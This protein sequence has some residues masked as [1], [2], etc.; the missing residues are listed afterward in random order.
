MAKTPWEIIKTNA[1][2]AKR[3]N[4][5]AEAEKNALAREE[6]R[7]LSNIEEVTGKKLTTVEEITKE[8]EELTRAVSERMSEMAKVLLEVDYLSEDDKNFLTEKG[9]L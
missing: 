9:V 6:T 8:K 3:D 4:V 1:E 2:K 7:I 5:N